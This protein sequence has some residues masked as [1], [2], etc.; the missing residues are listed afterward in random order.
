MFDLCERN[1]ENSKRNK[2]KMIFLTNTKICILTFILDFILFSK[3]FKKIIIIRLTWCLII[4]CVICIGIQP[5]LQ[6]CFGYGLHR[7]LFLGLLLG[8]LLGLVLGLLSSFLLIDLVPNSSDAV[9]PPPSPHVCAHPLNHWC[10]VKTNLLLPSH[11]SA[12][13]W[14]RILLCTNLRSCRQLTSFQ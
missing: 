1:T 6:L 10:F 5:I 11:I 8:F 3:L 4:D 2:G 7:S 13:Q 12:L 9:K 14:Y